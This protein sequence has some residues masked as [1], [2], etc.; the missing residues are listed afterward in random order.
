MSGMSAAIIA[1]TLVFPVASPVQ[2]DLIV[3]CRPAVPEDVQRTN[4]T[5]SLIARFEVAAGGLPRNVEQLK[6]WRG[7]SSI[8]PCLE[9]WRLV[10]A[11]IGSEVRVALSW[12][13]GVG[14][15]QMVIDVEGRRTVLLL[16]GSSPA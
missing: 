8:V 5:F 4:A 13:H 6:G 12:K 14:W 7:V 3:V 1:T 9:E 15:L 16:N 10:S 2:E 11:G